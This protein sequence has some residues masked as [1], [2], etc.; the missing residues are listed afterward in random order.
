MEAFVEHFHFTRPL[1]LLGIPLCL[2][3][4][5]SLRKFQQQ[6]S[7]WRH[8]ISPQLVE[9]LLDSTEKLRKRRF[10]PL[11]ASA[12][13][14][15][16][17][18]LAG[19]SWTKIPQ[20]IHKRQ[21]ALVILLDLSI[22]MYAEDVKPSR[23]V[24]AKRKLLDILRFRQEGLT[25]LIAYSGDAHV[26]APLTDDTATIASLVPALEPGI[27][28]SFGSN[29]VAAAQRALQMMR[30]AGV[31]EA[32]LL[33]ITDEILAD[34]EDE[35]AD[36]VNSNNV[37]LSILAIGTEAGAPIPLPEGG[38]F[39][40]NGGKIVVANG[41]H[42]VMS[43]LAR[44][45]G[46]RFT[47]AKLG[48]DDFKT[49]LPSGLEEKN[50]RETER[51]FDSWEDQG[52]WLVIASLPLAMLAFRRGWL[53]A[54]AI[55]LLPS[56]PQSS[57]AFSWQ[58]L[59]LNKDQQ[60]QQ[61]FKQ[62]ELENAAKL[63]NNKN[64]QGASHYRSGNYQAAAKAFANDHS[65]TG[66]YNRGNA[67][68]QSGELQAAIDAYNQALQ[69]DP[70]LESA[71]KNKAIVEK[72][73]EQQKQQQQQNDQDSQQQGSDNSQQQNGQQGQQQ[74]QS[75]EQNQSQSQNQSDSMQGDQQN[76]NPDKQQNSQQQQEQNQQATS[77]EQQQSEQQK[78]AQQAQ[79]GNEEDTE[80]RQQE[81]QEMQLTPEQIEQ[82]QA[83]EQW[84][85][86]VPDDPG[87]LLRRKFDYQYQQRLR[88]KRSPLPENGQV[89]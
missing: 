77:D 86:K 72:M 62:G 14:L 74:N 52:Y 43:R 15:T 66:D 25:G 50:T 31:S 3:L 29:S 63:F 60:G 38:F 30:D 41:N 49:L 17:V 1:W 4:L 33:F 61:A 80:Q 79:Q 10:L 71:A 19:P 69:K 6:S 76:Q 56:L 39:K 70:G 28:P 83:L 12:W 11:L 37:A 47:P 2:V 22:S 36:L 5:F 85:R 87:G 18:A 21:D 34:D 84:L 45:T 88:E 53:L 27:M 67:L 48:D 75:G 7:S 54:I 57:Y 24:Q 44:S 89:W 26:V 46:G 55:V 81:Q 23:L 51:E 82:Q 20:P 40:S 58:D 64:W 42:A 68:A 35:L 16:T 78:A 65:A 32:R 13:L 73:L 8:A 9:F 59:W